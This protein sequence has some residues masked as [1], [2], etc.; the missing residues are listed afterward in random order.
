MIWM[1]M[2]LRA[3][4]DHSRPDPTIVRD[5]PLPQCP[6]LRLCQLMKTTVRMKKPSSGHAP[7]CQLLPHLRARARP[8]VLK[9]KEKGTHIIGVTDLSLS[10]SPFIFI[11]KRRVINNL[12]QK[13]VH[14]LF[15]LCFSFFLHFCL[16][17]FFSFFTFQ[18]QKPGKHP[19]PMHAG[20][21]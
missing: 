17:S 2:L 16:F 10:P 11:I 21:S 7:R 4:T 5:Q 20:T 8:T 3:L 15:V 1:M 13:K 18:G 19:V 9:K 6:R 12:M 14:L